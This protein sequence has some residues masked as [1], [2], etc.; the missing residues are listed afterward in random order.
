MLIGYAR[1]SESSG[2]EQAQRDRLAAF[3]VDPPAVYVDHG[4]TGTDLPRPGL[5]A[6]LS[7]VVGGDTLV[8]TELARLGRSAA[9][10]GALAEDLR[11]RG[12]RLMFDGQSHDPKDSVGAAV[13]A[14]LASTFPRF[15]SE[16]MHLR[17]MEGNAR[18]KAAGGFPGRK[19]LLDPVRQAELYDLHESGARSVSELMRMFGVSRAGLYQYLARERDR[20]HTL[21]HQR[22]H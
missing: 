8:V 1:C 15:E 10:V 2:D 4:L 7:R 12:V 21:D 9:D 20:R 13:F 5:T 17:T 3:G 14:L 16:L 11:S 22:N 19:P 18:R 6:A